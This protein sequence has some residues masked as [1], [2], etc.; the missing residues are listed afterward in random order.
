MR[1]SLPHLTASLLAF[2]SCGAAA[3]HVDRLSLRQ[4]LAMTL[5]Q[6]NDIEVHNLAKLVEQ[7]R[8]KAAKLALDPQLEGSYVYQ[9]INT[10][11][12]TQD[13]VS[14]GGGT[15]GATNPADPILT[16]PR[17]FEQ[18][19]HVGKLALTNKFATGTQVELG[20]TFRVL[21]NTLNRQS[22]PS[23]YNPEFESFTGVTITQPLL[24][25]F[26]LG[27]NL[28]EIRIAKCNAKIADLEWRAQT[29]TTVAEVMKR[30]YDLVFTQQNV[31]V[32]QEAVELAE[33]L[34][35]DTQKRSKEGVA[36]GNDV[37][38]A[39]AGVYQRKEDLLAAQVQNIERQNALQ[40][41]F[42]HSD[43]IISNS[44]RVETIDSLLDAVP[45]TN[46]PT[47]MATALEK[48]WE[49]LQA[50]EAVNMRG[51]QT[52]LAGNQSLPRFDLV[53]SGGFH[54]L[55]NG[56]ESTYSRAFDRQ[57]PEWTAGAQFSM[58]LSWSHMRAP[59]RMA[60]GQEQQ[61]KV[62]AEKVRL[63]VALEIDTVLARLRA[64]EQRL[65]AARKSES[66]A[67]QSV[68]GELKRL[69]EGVST[70]FQVLQLQ[71]EYAQTRSRV[72]AVMTDLSKDLADLYLATGTLLDKQEIVIDSD[73]PK[74]VATWIAPVPPKV[75]KKS[76]ISRIFSKDDANDDEDDL[77]EVEQ[78]AAPK[79]KALP[80]KAAAAPTPAAAPAPAP[81]KTVAPAAAPSS[82]IITTVAAP[83]K[84][85]SAAKRASTP[86]ATAAPAP[87]SKASSTK[88][89]ASAEAA[90]PKAKRSWL[91]WLRAKP[92][93]EATPP[94]KAAPKAAAKPASRPAAPPPAASAS[95]QKG[96]PQ[97]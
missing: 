85:A 17:I 40:M 8:I 80:V 25:D 94:P 23:L 21:D 95:P 10:P 87:A 16:S 24:K 97:P 72:F 70:S 26:G 43:D 18:R 68:D 11:Q 67:R 39:E 51:H 66:A 53:G 83:A 84:P 32:Q 57:G 6:N 45:G 42:R 28:G 36:A 93:P 27:A 9:W 82:F 34:L 14:T 59:K 13:F 12:N 89:A 29:A 77:V 38:V 74:P 3:D 88:P 62:Q 60:E 7:E 48:R 73:L 47:L 96:T 64:D 30:Y 55:S 78:K 4:V 52:K 19:N 41:L 86:T 58:P 63:Q 76:W 5:E 71:R 56:T 35:E 2:A 75:E 81:V 22:P 54:G 1:T 49:V 37:L 91:S 33:K 31:R 46:R 90:A 65:V 61:A 20:T 15:L 44:T 50:D 79:I 69:K 92:K